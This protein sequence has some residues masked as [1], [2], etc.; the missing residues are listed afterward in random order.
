MFT[1][2]SKSFLKALVFSGALVAAASLPHEVVAAGNGPTVSPLVVPHVSPELDSLPQSAPG[3]GKPVLR[4]KPPNIPAGPVGADP[5][6]EA[7]QDALAAKDRA[8][9]PGART[10]APVLNFQ[11]QSNTC[12]CSPPDTTG[13]AGPNHYVQ[14]VNATGL[15]IY[16]KAGIILA[17]YPKQLNALWSTTPGNCDSGNRGDPNVLYDELAD[18]WL[19][20]QFFESGNGVCIAVSQTGD[21]TGSYFL[22]EFTTPDFPDYFKFGVWPNAY[23]MSANEN[24]YT[25]YAFNRANMLAGSPATFIRFSGETNLLLP[26][27]LDGPTGPAAN[28]PGLFYTFKDNTFHGGTDRLELFA[29]SPDFATPGNST[30]TKILSPP[31]TPFVY[32]VCGF[33]VMN[34]IPQ[35]GT[36]QKVDPVS[37]WPMHRFAYRNFGT[38]QSLVG[39]F[40]V[41]GARVDTGAIRWF[42]L[43]NQGAGWTL[44]QQGTIDSNNGVSRTMG[45]IAQDK[46]GNIGIGY[47][48]F[49][50]AMNPAL[51]Y[52]V[53]APG[54]ALGVMQAE[55]TLIAGTGSQ[56]GSNRWG[57][58]SG[59]AVDPSDDKTFWFTGE[60]YAATSLNG[61]TTRI[62]TFKMP[63]S[64]SAM[65]TASR[66]GF[67][68]E[69]SE[70]SSVGGTVSAAATTLNVGDTA[71]DRQ[72]RGFLS[73][74]TSAIPDGAT[75]TG[76]S[77]FVKRSG[78]VTGGPFA[79]LGKLLVDI[80]TGFF[81]TSVTLQPADFQAASSLGGGT[82]IPNTPV[83]G[84]YR[85][86][87]PAAVFGK[88]S[89][90]GNTQLRLRFAG[91]DDNDNSADFLRLFS[92]NNA[93]DKPYLVVTY[94]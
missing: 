80:K 63:P 48:V 45:S 85:S 60:Y 66:D 70:S 9:E 71:A 68:T 13:D 18:R 36:A 27:D 31:V 57:D 92:G 50:S 5:E 64:I 42:E 90:T 22:Y 19:L 11:G 26:A 35:L 10:P 82:S 20:S 94:N 15:A 41:E 8:V 61:W 12:A 39:T 43:R 25:A 54:D 65:S 73:F 14:L 23:Y 88:I 4:K 74:D 2:F 46:D 16:N 55:R 37:E 34:C 67:V 87:F 62:G 6:G 72:M 93:V 89:K 75:I 38:H 79:T 40:T 56:T 53:R 44:Y 7:A 77:L 33:F 3:I 17:G 86:K 78:L 47:S 69:T 84:W 58:Y 76:A 81:G 24:S 30:F 1:T 28:A 32:T 59:M 52:T 49:S 83:T 21:P 91:D 29:L 51:R